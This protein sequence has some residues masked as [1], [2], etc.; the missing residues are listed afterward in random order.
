MK[1]ETEEFCET[2]HGEREVFAPERVTS[3][4]T[5]PPMKP[6]PECCGRDK[7]DWE[8]ERDFYAE[9]EQDRI[10]VERNEK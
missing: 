7:I 10:E 5:C 1:P 4:S 9:C 6:C 3:A 8:R 2:C